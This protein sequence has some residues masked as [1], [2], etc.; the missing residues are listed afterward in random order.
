[1]KVREDAMVV[2]GTVAAVVAVTVIGGGGE[3]RVGLRLDRPAATA[4]AHRS[5]LLPTPLLPADARSTVAFRSRAGF[6]EPT[7]T[8]TPAPRILR[9]R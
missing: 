2:A 9:A 1:M 3:R 7:A 5:T 8:P 6:P 4:T